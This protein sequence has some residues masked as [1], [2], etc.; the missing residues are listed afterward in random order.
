M[1]AGGDAP[2]SWD[3][4]GLLASLFV[5]AGISIFRSPLLCFL[6]H[7]STLDVLFLLL[8]PL[9]LFLA[10]QDT[11]GKVTVFEGSFEESTRKRS[12]TSSG[13]K[14]CALAVASS[15]ATEAAGGSASFAHAQGIRCQDSRAGREGRRSAQS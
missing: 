9:L 12:A 8:L 3:A 5:V 13:R 7:A 4:V 2:E 14:T 11:P 1:C 10:A 6:V 15:V